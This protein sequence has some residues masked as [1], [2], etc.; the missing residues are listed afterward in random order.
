MTQAVALRDEVKIV[1]R[2]C[3]GAFLIDLKGDTYAISAED[4][5]HLRNIVLPEGEFDELVEPKDF[6]AQLA[7]AGLI[8]TERKTSSRQLALKCLIMLIAQVANVV[9]MPA[10][11]LV[12]CSHILLKRFS[13]YDVAGIWTMS[14][15]QATKRSGRYSPSDLGAK[16]QQA[17]EN[18][19]FPVRCKERALVAFAL[20][21]QEGYCPDLVVGC[22]Q[23]CFE[24]HCWAEVSGQVLGDDP[25]RCKELTEIKRFVRSSLGAV[26]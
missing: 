11:W 21:S 13:W 7:E 23:P 9:P 19:V 24:L 5:I 1:W 17:I 26:N 12:A 14:F 25:E 3:G 6:L 2:D 8:Q 20:A 22:A 4:A 10:V 18:S 16:A 15:Q